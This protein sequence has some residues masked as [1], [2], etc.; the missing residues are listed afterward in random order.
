MAWRP[1][2]RPR[3]TVREPDPFGGRN[4]TMGPSLLP[5]DIDTAKPA[6]AGELTL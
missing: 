5:L 6:G 1:R 3:H 2:E 4:V